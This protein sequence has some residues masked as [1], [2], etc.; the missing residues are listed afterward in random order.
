MTKNAWGPYTVVVT[1]VHDGDTIYGTATVDV[2]FN[3]TVELFLKMRV[4]GINADELSTPTG[5]AA[6]DFALTLLKPGDQVTV[7]SEGWDK[8]GGRCDATITL[9]DGTD[10]ATA[11]IAANEAVPWNGKGPK[12]TV[13]A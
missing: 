12:P 8:Y 13:A 7:V 3:V 6:R 4:D 9:A 11:M 1:D 5:K 2:G 10:F